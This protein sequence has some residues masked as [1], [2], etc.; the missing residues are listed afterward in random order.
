MG[1]G[2]SLHTQFSNQYFTAWST[3]VFTDDVLD[4]IRTTLFQCAWC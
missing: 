1:E 4:V 2:Y 3:V